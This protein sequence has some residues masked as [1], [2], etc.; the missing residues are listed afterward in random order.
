[1]TPLLENILAQPAAWK[2]VARHHSGEG[3]DAL[4]R[5]ATLLATRKKL[6]ISGMG[7][8]LFAGIAFSYAASARY[9]SV[10]T[11]DASEL[12]YFLDSQID[13]DTALLLISRSGESIE[14]TK[15]L[16]KVRSRGAATLGI[17]NVPGSSLVSMADQAILLASPPDEFVAIQTYTA[18]VATLA[19]LDAA[20]DGE[21]DSA[22]G[23][24]NK[25]SDLLQEWIT[26]CVRSRNRWDNFL[27]TGGPIYFLSRGPG[28]GSVAEG[29]L[30]MHETAK[31]PA[32][33][34]SIAQFR[35]GP[36]EAVDRNFRAVVLGTQEQTVEL[37]AAFA[38][39]VLAMGAEVRWLGPSVSGCNALPLCSWPAGTPTRFKGM[40]ETIPLQLLAYRKAELSGVRPGQFRWAPL[41]TTTESGFALSPP[42]P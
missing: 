28:L 34:M 4:E 29:V 35:H 11:I 33:G 3:R 15:L 30:L 32:V 36:V 17:A 25:M 27:S 2:A 18:T 40:V 38:N 5:A 37:D 7:A 6:V 9:P 16:E 1:M 12:L 19:L 42:Q 31:S 8:S 21:L 14:I 26:E 41:I 23:D 13:S 22:A 10:Q 20:C 39:D 24:L